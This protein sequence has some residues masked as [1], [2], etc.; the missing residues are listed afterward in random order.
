MKMRNRFKILLYIIVVLIILATLVLISLN[1]ASNNT[2]V[3][4]KT[5]EKIENYNYVL[6][7]RDTDY[8]KELFNNLKTTLQTEEVNMEEYAS[9]LTKIFVADLFTL[10]NKDN[11]Y[12]VG[13]LLYIYPDVKENYRLNVEDT[14]YKYLID[15][16]SK[17]RQKDLPNVTNVEVISIEN[18]TYTYMKEKLNAYKLNVSISYEKDLLYPNYAEIILVNSDNYLYVVSF[19]G[20]ES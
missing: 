8:M 15:I 10:K 14:L 11:K 2:K 3:E 19:K 6:K 16:N 12:D 13:G 20:V 4:H 9:D 17:E 18:T 1:F 5:I 7:D